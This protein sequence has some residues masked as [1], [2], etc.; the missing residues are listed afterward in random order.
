[1]P[2]DTAPTPE[3]R[4]KIAALLVIYLNALQNGPGLEDAEW[5]AAEEMKQRIA[6]EL[7]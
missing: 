7:P 1:M 4:Q 5:A 6:S 2:A 3:S